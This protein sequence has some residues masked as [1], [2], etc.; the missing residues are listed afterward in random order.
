MTN[1]KGVKPAAV[2]LSISPHS[3]IIILFIKQENDEWR[4]VKN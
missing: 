3:I 2:D 4:I 1:W